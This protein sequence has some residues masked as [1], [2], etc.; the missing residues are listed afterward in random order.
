MNQPRGDSIIWGDVQTFATQHGRRGVAR[1]AQTFAKSINI[2]SK[3]RPHEI[4]LKIYQNLSKNISPDVQTFARLSVT[5]G[6][7]NFR[8]ASQLSH[9]AAGGLSPSR[10]N[11]RLLSPG[12]T[13]DGIDDL[14]AKS[15][16]MT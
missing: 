1:G 12:M 16:T 3:A 11:F 4:L 2:I 9:F 8:L 13:H 6:L 7:A 5:E 10:A 15:M 14:R